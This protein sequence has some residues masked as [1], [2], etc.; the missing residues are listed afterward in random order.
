VKKLG[1]C[2]V[3]CLLSFV[4]YGS[5]PAAMSGDGESPADARVSEYVYLHQTRNGNAALQT[6]SDGG[7]LQ[8]GER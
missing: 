2:G 1:L 7:Q 3:A 4:A 5:M 8:C 6:I